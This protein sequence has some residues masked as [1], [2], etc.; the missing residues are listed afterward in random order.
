MGP[1]DEI[2][3]N[4][5]ELWKFA[6]AKTKEKFRVE[7]KLNPEMAGWVGWV[8]LEAKKLF[9]ELKRNR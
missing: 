5:N 6:L 4:E 2:P 1:D 3:T 7:R 8:N 9:A